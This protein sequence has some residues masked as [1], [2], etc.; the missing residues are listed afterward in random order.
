M[1]QCNC[2]GQC[3]LT[4]SCAPPDAR[5]FGQKPISST[6]IEIGF[7][8]PDVGDILGETMT[9]KTIVTR[10]EHRGTACV[11]FDPRGRE[12]PALITEVWGPQCINLVY[13]NDVEGQTDSYGQKLLRA[14]SVMHG[15]IQQAHGN[16]W[17]LPGETREPLPRVND[18]AL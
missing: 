2:T 15:S 17:M 18:S 11:F 16:F 4:G 10:E 6:P 3:R 13:V 8:I 1:S 7:G 14:T 9:A 12:Y 5:V